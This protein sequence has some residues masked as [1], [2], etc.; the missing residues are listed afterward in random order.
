[1]KMDDLLGLRTVSQGAVRTLDA[2]RTESP[3]VPEFIARNEIASWYYLEFW[4][5]VGC[6][7]A[8]GVPWLFLEFARIPFF[9]QYRIQP[10]KVGTRAR[11]LK[12]SLLATANLFFVT[13][14]FLAP[15]GYL[16]VWLGDALVETSPDALPGVPAML[17][18]IAFYQV[19][20]DLTF[21]FS[22]RL[23]H[24][25]YWYR[26]IHKTHHEFTAPFAYVA[27]Y[28]D[29][30][31]VLLGNDLPAFSGATFQILLGYRPHLFVAL[32]YLAYRIATTLH[33]HSGYDFPW[34][35]ERFLPL[36][37]GPVHHD[38]HHR[39]FNG[40]FSSTLTYLDVLFRTRF[41]DVDRAAKEMREKKKK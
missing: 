30:L 11:S 37:A 4:L 41:E 21:Y 29:P 20:E 17:L 23:L 5:V 27:I 34:S 3:L 33:V 13:A 25:P 8:M 39:R 28:A 16:C 40:N 18:T 38:E 26:K 35:P 31:E 6:Y 12:Y 14:A 22:H 24:T 32:V 2:W 15:F 19:S 36:Y 9:E 1:M 10:D 7:V